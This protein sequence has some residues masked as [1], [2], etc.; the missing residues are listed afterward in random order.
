M[1]IQ[2]QY[3]NSKNKYF[4]ELEL[5]VPLIFYVSFWVCVIC[6]MHILTLIG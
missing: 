2:L 6:C 5:P 4:A 1:H 3:L